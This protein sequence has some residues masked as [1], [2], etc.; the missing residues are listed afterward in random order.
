MAGTGRSLP[1]TISPTRTSTS[2]LLSRTCSKSTRLVSG[3]QQS[4]RHPSP[5][6]PSGCR[7][8]AVLAPEQ[9]ST[10]GPAQ[11][12]VA[13][14]PNRS[15]HQHTPALPRHLAA[16][17]HRLHRHSML[18]EQS[19]RDRAIPSATTPTILTAQHL[20]TAPGRRRC[21]T[22]P[23]WSRA[24]MDLAVPFRKEE[25]TRDKCASQAHRLAPMALST[26]SPLQVSE[27][28][29]TSLGHSRACR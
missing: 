23:A 4:T 5:A 17:S 6:L 12:H 15:H 8:R 19:H 28:R 29:Q 14:R 9:W 22:L 16:C 10:A 7:R 18:I 1:S 27:H 13:L 20:G 11:Q 24:L 3:C 25:T 21:N 2:M 26:T